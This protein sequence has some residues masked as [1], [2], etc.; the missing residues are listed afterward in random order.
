M[1]TS[2][3]ASVTA[4]VRIDALGVFR[5]AGADNSKIRLVLK[6]VK[7]DPVLNGLYDINSNRVWM[8]VDEFNVNYERL[9]AISYDKLL[10]E[11]KAFWIAMVA[12]LVAHD[13]TSPNVSLPRLL[14]AV[15]THIQERVSERQTANNRVTQYAGMPL[16]TL[17]VH[18]ADIGTLPYT[19]REITETAFETLRFAA[20]ERNLEMYVNQDMGVTVKPRVQG[21]Q[22][23]GM[24]GRSILDCDEGNIQ[25][26]CCFSSRTLGSIVAD[27]LLAPKKSP[28]LKPC[29]DLLRDLTPRARVQLWYEELAVSYARHMAYS[30]L[31][32]GIAEE[33]RS[34]GAASSAGHGRVVEGVRKVRA[35]LF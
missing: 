20:Q 19:L 33:I 29:D 5:L 18:S 10:I 21:E 13:L 6:A 14:S 28:Y 27:A 9:Q 32:T 7:K 26:R 23:M 16:E 25:D 8:S 35:A 3:T 2:S 4:G 34:A 17:G 30:K 31:F 15:N 24:R 1:R 12:S 22:N 11:D